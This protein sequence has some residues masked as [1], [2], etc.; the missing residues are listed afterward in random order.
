MR[1]LGAAMCLENKCSTAASVGLVD[2]EEKLQ[3]SGVLLSDLC[4]QF[5]LPTPSPMPTDELPAE[6]SIST[7]SCL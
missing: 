5:V 6:P 2:V 7:C 4:L 1:R 3:W